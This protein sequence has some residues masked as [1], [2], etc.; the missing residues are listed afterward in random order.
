MSAYFAELYSRLGPIVSGR[1]F[2]VTFPQE[3]LP[4][5]PAIRYTPTGGAI[6]KTNCGDAND[7]D[8]SVQVDIVAKEFAHLIPLLASVRSSLSSFSVPCVLESEPAFEYDSETKT[9][10]VILQ[11]TIA[12]S[13]TF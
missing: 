10:R 1:A 5:W 6:E 2:P 9:H 7:G 11:Y 12:G 4:T 13:Y 3:P 8:V